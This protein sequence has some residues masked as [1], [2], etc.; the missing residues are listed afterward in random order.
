MI[1][2]KNFQVM[3]IKRIFRLFNKRKNPTEEE[4]KMKK[5]AAVIAIVLCVT[6]LG[7]AFVG[8]NQDK[9]QGKTFVSMDINPSV[10]M[11]V[12][13][14]NKVES[15]EAANEDAQIMLYGE[16][17][18]GKTLDEAVEII[19]NLAIECGYLTEENSGVNVTV[20]AGNGKADVEAKVGE[21]ISTKINA[22]AEKGK[23]SVNINT[24]GSFS[25]QRQ[26]EY[27]KEKY[28]DSQAVQSLTVG[29]LKLVLELTEKDGS[30][31]FEAAAELDTDALI[32]DIEEAY[33]KIEPYATAAYE[34][35]VKEASELYAIAK[36]TALGAAWTGAYLKQKPLSVPNY[37][38]IYAAYD[39]A[40]VTLD[41]TLDKIE[42]ARSYANTALKNVDTQKI[43]D[44]LG[45]EKSEVD[46]A[47]KDENGD[48]TLESLEA[49]LDREL[50]NMSKEAYDK[51]K[52]QLP[53]LEAYVNGLQAEV[54][55]FI[56][57]LPEEYATQI[58]Q[59]IADLEVL[60]GDVAEFIQ[61][62][63]DITVDDVRTI[64]TYFEKQRDQAMEQIKAELT[65]E[66]F[67]EAQADVAAVDAK[68]KQFEDKFT[69]A[70]EQAK[71]EAQAYLQAA[72]EKLT[73]DNEQSAA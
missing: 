68:I 49:Y 46:A 69:A 66:Q 28:P 25:L 14:D 7:A 11:V 20:V 10:N 39:V 51:I 3:P 65:E 71:Q 26:L 37:G 31:S 73:A 21:I 60:G 56:D 42:E 4:T 41:Y 23:I 55:E 2:K 53:E 22:A 15:V 54:D 29:R 43:A 27:Y 40:A 12:D 18:V 6:M 52:E 62:L 13:K 35:A 59:I 45:V 70:V 5:F 36:T 19:A 72:K 1:G 30:I 8:C 61:S 58:R 34:K 38:A 24:Q 33:A 57:S 67:N 16:V 48:V 17:I 63:G 64:V 44:L 9:D 47:I 32:A 50:K